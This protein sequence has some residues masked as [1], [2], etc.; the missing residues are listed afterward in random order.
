M[1]LLG[2]IQQNDLT[3]FRRDG[4]ATTG[5]RGTETTFHD[6]RRHTQSCTVVSVCSLTLVGRGHDPCAWDSGHCGLC[7]GT[8]LMMIIEMNSPHRVL[9]TSH[10]SEGDS[11]NQKRRA[12]LIHINYI[13]LMFCHFVVRRTDAGSKI[14]SAGRSGREPGSGF[15]IRSRT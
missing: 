5:L 13:G 10:G 14:L 4:P 15:E 12:F 11:Q 1:E 3:L 7:T 8:H 9:Q 2:S 6:S